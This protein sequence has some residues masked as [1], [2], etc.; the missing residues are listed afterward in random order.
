[1]YEAARAGA[2]K[3]SPLLNSTYNC[4]MHWLHNSIKEYAWGSFTALPEFLGR[5]SPA[6]RPQAELWVGAHPRGTS[7]LWQGGQWVPLD[8]FLSRTPEALGPGWRSL[9]FLLKV[10]AVEKPLSL[11]A[12]PNAQQARQGYAR[13]RRLG[14][15]PEACNYVDAN[16]KPELLCAL[17]PFEALLGFEAPTRLWPL[18]EALALPGLQPCLPLLRQADEAQA[19]RTFFQSLLRWPP[20][21][22][23]GLLAAAKPALLRLAQEGE[24]ANKAALA[25]RLREAYPEDMGVLASLCLNLVRLKPL[26]AVYVPAGCLHAY[27]HGLGVE[28]MA[29][30]DNVLRGGLSPKRVEVEALLSMLCFESYVPRVQTALP[31]PGEAWVLEAPVEEFCFSLVR[32]APRAPFAPKRSGPELLLVLEGKAVAQGPAGTLSFGRGQS[33]FVSA[34][35]GPYMLMGEA[36]VARVTTG[37]A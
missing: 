36:L 9:P 17:T 14:L 11:Q 31:G 16:H 25:L 37:G 7:R 22:R 13:E 2:K 21:K 27:M 35:E 28:V 1:M 5:P 4:F 12:H 24:F 18:F 30:S 23:P 32:V 10:L 8:V 15:P 20:A 3:L 26:E 6:P 34:D 19:L 33:A 29:N